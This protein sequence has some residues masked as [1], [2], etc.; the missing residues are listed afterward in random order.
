MNGILR[1]LIEWKLNTFFSDEKLM[2]ISYEWHYFMPWYFGIICYDVSKDTLRRS[3]PLVW[4][5]TLFKNLFYQS[6]KHLRP[7]YST[8]IELMDQLLRL[9]H[10]FSA[11]NKFLIPT[12][13]S[14]ITCSYL[15]HNHLKI[16]APSHLLYYFQFDCPLPKMLFKGAERRWVKNNPPKTNVRWEQ[17]SR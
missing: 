2:I 17:S 4:L 13:I 16:E 10:T 8:C 9:E 3:E 15:N 7:L 5:L 12:T 11:I 14:R 6:A 1:L